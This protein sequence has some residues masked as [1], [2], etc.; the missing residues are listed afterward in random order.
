MQFERF[1]SCLCSLVSLGPKQQES[2]EI[3][4]ID[5]TLGA[6]CVGTSSIL[7]PGS[8]H[9]YL[10]YSCNFL[11]SDPTERSSSREFL[12][13]HKQISLNHI[14]TVPIVLFLKKALFILFLYACMHVCVYTA[15]LCVCTMCVYMCVLS[16]TS[17][18]LEYNSQK[19]YS[20]SSLLPLCGIQGTSSGH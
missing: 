11:T 1:S 6:C 17:W 18:R 14:L 19:L 12:Q 9:S 4:G 8:Y 15:C 20:E 7:K 5:R 16:V 10:P 2:L 3:P 13:G